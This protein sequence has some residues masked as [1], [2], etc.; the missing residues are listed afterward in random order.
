[1]IRPARLAAACA[2]ALLVCGGGALAAQQGEAGPFFYRGLDFGSQ[3]VFNPLTMLLNTGFDSFQFPNQ[4]ARVF[5][6]DYASSWTEV[7][8][9]LVHPLKAGSGRGWGNF[10]REE[11]L[12]VRFTT[13]DA[14]WIPNYSLHL[15]GLGMDYAAL[16]EFYE[17]HGIRGAAPLAALT[18]FLAGV[19]NEMAENNGGGFAPSPGTVADLYVFNVGGLILFTPRSVRRFFARKLL[20]ADWSEMP[21]FM[22]DGTLQDVG[23]YF[24]V[25]PALPGLDRTRLFVRFGISAIV[26]LSRLEP[27][28]STWSVGVGQTGVYHTVDPDTRIEN[29]ELDWTAGLFYDRDNSLLMSVVWARSARTR[30]KLD[31][32]PGV[33]PGVG[34][35]VGAW[36]ALDQQ[37]R[38]HLGVAATF[39]AG[40]GIGRSW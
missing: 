25:K 35:D 14:G 24:V 28:G 29:I 26:G 33:L 5:R 19:L 39:T 11:I 38:L 18:A 20:L 22:A 15:V 12:P 1:M 27:D 37:W 4:D 6:Y 7:R 8:E 2:V 21:T 16:D 32:Y 30:F 40:L 13:H 10:F 9:A 31:L 34:H 17:A 23:Q 36:A 3:R